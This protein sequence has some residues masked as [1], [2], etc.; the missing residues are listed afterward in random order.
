M[1][2]SLGVICGETSRNRATERGQDAF[3]K[4]KA[5]RYLS[6]PQNKLREKIDGLSTYVRLKRKPPK[7]TASTSIVYDNSCADGVFLDLGS[8][9]A[10]FFSCLKILLQPRRSGKVSVRFFSNP[11]PKDTAVHTLQKSGRQ[12]IDILRPHETHGRKHLGLRCQVPSFIF[13]KSINPFSG[14]T[15]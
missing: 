14:H 7:N 4:R 9:V 3:R 5:G 11:S 13:T 8:A 1:C 15:I 6:A 12:S 2:L 10:T